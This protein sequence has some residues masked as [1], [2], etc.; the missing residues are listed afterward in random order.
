[1]AQRHILNYFYKKKKWRWN[2]FLP[3]QE[4]SPDCLTIPV[5]AEIK[6]L[7][8]NGEIEQ[9]R[10]A[11]RKEGKQGKKEQRVRKDIKI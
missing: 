4:M 1:M 8:M 3:K 5:M 9:L 10:W 11:K 6:N 7:W 2:R